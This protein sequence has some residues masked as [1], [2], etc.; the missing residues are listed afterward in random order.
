MPSCLLKLR[1]E[2]LLEGG[3]DS[4]GIDNLIIYNILIILN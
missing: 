3:L 1:V 2:S 4:Q